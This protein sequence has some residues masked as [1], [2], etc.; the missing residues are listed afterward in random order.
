MLIMIMKDGK[1]R[2][3]NKGSRWKWRLGKE[4]QKKKVEKKEIRI[5]LRLKKMQEKSN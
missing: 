5:R 1:K 4:K 3:G 2:R